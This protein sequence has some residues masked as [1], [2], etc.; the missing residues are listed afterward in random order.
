MEKMGYYKPETLKKFGFKTESEMDDFLLEHGT[1]DITDRYPN[2]RNN[3]INQTRVFLDKRLQG[4]QTKI[5]VSTML[6]ANA[7]Q[8]GDSLSSFRIEYRD[9]DGKI[10]DGALYELANKMVVETMQ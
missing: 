6:K 7:D 4:N 8:D 5:S 9:K 2:T 10:V 3:S 1:F